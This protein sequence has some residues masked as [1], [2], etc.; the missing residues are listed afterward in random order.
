MLK[1]E[2]AEEGLLLAGKHRR[3]C[4]VVAKKLIYMCPP[5]SAFSALPLKLGL[6]PHDLS[7]RRCQEDS[8]LWS[9]I[10]PQDETKLQLKCWTS[11][12]VWVAFL[13]LFVLKLPYF[14]SSLH[15]CVTQWLEMKALI[16]Y[17]FVDTFCDLE[18]TNLSLHKH[19]RTIHNLLKLWVSLCR[20]QRGK[21]Q[22]H[23]E[24]LN[25][26]LCW[27]EVLAAS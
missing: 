5:R 13:S 9:A 8:D 22:K 16:I 7:W 1:P 6:H 4:A 19:L 27:Q 15:F 10:F 14:S 17:S 21:T 25:L 3:F 26:R 23:K 20:W 2:T 11:W 18:K 12:W 24:M